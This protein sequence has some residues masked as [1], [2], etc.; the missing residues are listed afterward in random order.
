VRAGASRYRALLAL[1]GARAPV[2]A[3]ALGSMPIGMFA[4]AI[5]LLGRDATGSFA[6]AGRVAAAF[7]LANALGAVAQGRLMD[8]LGQPC[9]LRT[10]AAGHLVAL[11]ALV[12]AADRDAPSW[13]LVLCAVAGGACLPQLPAAMRALWAA[14]VEDPERRQTAYALVAVVFEVSVVTAP[15][16]VAAIAAVVSPAAAVLVAALLGGGS[17]LA[18]SATPASRRWRGVAHDTGWLGPLGAPGMRTLLVVLAAMG[19]AV[20]VVQVLVPAY[21]DDRGSTAIAGFLLAAL[22]AGSLAGGV[23][24]GARSW[25]G[26]PAA[27]LP[28]L[29]LGLGAGF[30]ALAAVDAPVLLAAL[31]LLS[32]LLLAPTSVVGST[33]L[34][35]VV[36]RGSVTEA[37]TVMV[38][39]IVAGTA[40]GNAVGGAVVEA[41]S[42]VAAALT[43]GGVA[44]AGAA[45]AVARRGTLVGG[46]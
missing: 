25:P 2:I 12:V 13:V 17:A 24:Y 18:F 4:L 1:P 44:V 29:L 19:A 31:L 20:G 22:S 3:S 40:A 27:R 38:M 30:A 6:A 15:V 16:L 10:A 26:A 8:R 45:F 23:V 7:G 5:L 14:L 11:G 41:G 35:A 42:H 34:D 33:L 28:V 36:P 9:V 37:F 32:G 43:A 46:R 21:A 39:G